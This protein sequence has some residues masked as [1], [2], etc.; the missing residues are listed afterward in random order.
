VDLSRIGRTLGGMVVD[1]V[2]PVADYAALMETLFD[3]GAIRAMFAGGFRM[4]MDS[5]CAVT[6]PYAVEILENRLGARR[7]PCV[8]ATPC[9]IS[10]ACIPTR[11]RP[12]PRP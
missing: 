3:F 8:N 9:R 6:G 12:G 10:A 11:T 1:V 7:A 4:R 2:D 5:M